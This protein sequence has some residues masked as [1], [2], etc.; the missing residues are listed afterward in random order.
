MKTKWDTVSLTS[1]HSDPSGACTFNPAKVCS[2]AAALA[3]TPTAKTVTRANRFT[4]SRLTFELSG[5]Q[6][7]AKPDVGRKLERRVRLDS[8]RQPSAWMQI[9]CALHLNAASLALQ[10]Q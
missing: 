8:N 6:Q 1:F 9:R 7:Q 3:A 10:P 5:G 2:E 4:M